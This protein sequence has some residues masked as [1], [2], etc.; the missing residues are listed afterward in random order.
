MPKLKI[1]VLAQGLKVG[2]LENIILN[3]ATNLNNSNQFEIEICCYDTK[4]AYYEDL[5]NRGFRLHFLPRAHG[6]DW[7]YPYK[8][9]RIIHSNKID[10]IHAH[11]FTAWFYAALAAFLTRIPLVYTEHDNSFLSSKHIVL[12]SSLSKIFT[13]KIIAVSETVKSSLKQYCRINGTSVIYNGVDENT[14]NPIEARGRRIRKKKYG[15][16]E[17]DLLLGTVGRIDALKNQT[18]IIETI[19]KLNYD[20][21]VKLIII[22]DGKLRVD[23]ERTVKILNLEDRVIFL[24]ERRDI[25][26][27]LSILDI[28]ILP[29]LS[30]GLPVCLIEAMAVGLPIIASDVGGIPELISN[31]EN[32]ILINPADQGSL[33][34]A[35]KTILSSENTRKKMGEAGRII[36]KEKFSLDTM[37]NNYAEIYKQCLY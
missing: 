16:A 3:L 11:N 1:L 6:I 34:T 5:V 23:L 29:S 26:E 24:G 7:L 35:L 22:G 19:S 28:F 25:S 31:N 14:F 9:A 30:E 21:T 32:G 4:G 12:I 2:G 36:F 27:L 18:L 15:F 8:L 37:V 33:L 13:T 20:N 10:L 17:T